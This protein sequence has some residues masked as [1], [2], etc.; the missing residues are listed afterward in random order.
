MLQDQ[1]HCITLCRETLCS[2][3]MGLEL[4]SEEER[5]SSHQA[6]RLCDWKIHRQPVTGRIHSIF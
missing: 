6:M 4:L 3:I 2:V 5:T 1:E